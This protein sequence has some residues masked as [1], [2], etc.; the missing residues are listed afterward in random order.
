[1]IAADDPRRVLQGAALTLRPFTVA[2]ISVRYLSWLV[3][4]EVTRFLEIRHAVQTRETAT[5]FVSAFAGP[6]EKYMWGI[7]NR[8]TGLI[9]TTTLYDI[10]RVHGLSELGLLIGDKEFW[11]HGV[12]AETVNLVAGFAFDTL[13]LR[14]LS[15]GSYARNHGMNFT[16]RRLGFTLEGKQRKAFTVAPGEFVDGFRWGLSAEEWRESRRLAGGGLGE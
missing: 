2:D 5:A 13:N 15:G 16:Y 7:E 14:R 9:G 6:V 4:P 12:S 3:D 10:N 8:E 11:G 1:M